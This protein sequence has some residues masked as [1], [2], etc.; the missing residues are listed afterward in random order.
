[1]SHGKSVNCERSKFRARAQIRASWIL[2][3]STTNLHHNLNFGPGSLI[4]QVQVYIFAVNILRSRVRRIL[5]SRL[6]QPLLL[7][8]QVICLGSM[9]RNEIFKKNAFQARNFIKN[10]LKLKK[11]KK[12]R[13]ENESS[14][15][16]R[17]IN[18]VFFIFYSTR[19]CQSKRWLNKPGRGNLIRFV[20]S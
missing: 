5:N 9:T 16:R 2:N 11:R 15:D 19:N 12:N 6:N 8:W 10:S 20:H 13:R 17:G 18:S 14:K 4:L 1:M 3:T 7:L